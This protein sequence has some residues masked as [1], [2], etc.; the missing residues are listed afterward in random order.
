MKKQNND[1]VSLAQGKYPWV[2]NKTQ[3]LILHNHE[4][5]QQKT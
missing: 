5:I 3:S 4:K 1:T 2:T